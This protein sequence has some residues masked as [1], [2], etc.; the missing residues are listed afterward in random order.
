[1]QFRDANETDFEGCLPLLQQL[2]PSLKITGADVEPQIFQEIKKV[3]Y[4]LLKNPDAKVI[5][6]EADG[7]IIGLLDLTFRETLF[8]RG[9]TMIIEDLIVDENYRRRR[10]GTQLV[11]LAEEI[12][13][14]RSCHTIELNSDL[15][16][17]ET[18]RFWEAI[19]YECKA[20]QFRK[21]IKQNNK[22]KDLK[23]VVFE[24]F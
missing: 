16:R 2:W 3:F 14:R 19:G 21:M 18:H 24:E 12:A 5:L 15:Y 4:Q 9:W 13:Q 23:M 6:A 22:G 7:Q 10:I 1:M 20:Y 11:R 8:Y 17:K